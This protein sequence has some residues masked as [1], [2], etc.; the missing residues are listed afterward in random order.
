MGLVK[1][2]DDYRKT[3]LARAVPHSFFQDGAWW[4]QDE[5]GVDPE[6]ARVSL[7]LLPALY[8]TEP[9]LVAAARLSAVDTTPIDFA[10]ARWAKLYPEGRALVYDPWQRVLAAIKDL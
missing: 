5:G 10:T 9:E 1:L 4:L 3:A 8:G 6:S 7:K 2:T